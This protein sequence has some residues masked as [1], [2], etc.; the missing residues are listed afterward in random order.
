MRF[1]SCRNCEESA[2]GRDG[3]GCIIIF[4]R[5]LDGVSE[6]TLVFIP[7]KL[8]WWE[9]NERREMR[10]K[11]KGQEGGRWGKSNAGGAVNVDDDRKADICTKRGREGVDGRVRGEDMWV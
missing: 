1:L 5:R 3:L 9:R 6:S 2:Q 11:G 4:L 7:F 8:W 10:A